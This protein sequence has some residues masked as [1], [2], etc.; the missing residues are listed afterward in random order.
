MIQTDIAIVGG[1]LIGQALALGLARQGLRSV[2]IDRTPAE[3]MRRDDFDGRAYAV[4]L[5][6]RRFLRHLGVWAAIEPD[7]GP[8]NDIL[9]SDSRP[10]ERASPL[11]LRFDH[12]E[13]GPEGF[14]HMVEDRHLRRALL[15]AVAA[16][17]L[18]A[19]LDGVDVLELGKPSGAGVE[20]R[21]ADGRSIEAAV[22]VGADG[23]AGRVARAVGADKIT[24]AYDQV[25]LVCAVAHEK[26]HHGVAHEL[27]LPAGPFAILPLQGGR[28]ASIVWT[29]RKAAAEAFQRMDD[30]AYLSEVARRFGPFLGRLSLIG[31]RW[32]YPLSLSLADRFVAERLALVGDA[33]RGI[34]PIAGQGMNYGLRDAAALAEVLGDAARLGEDIGSEPVLQRYQRMRLA[35]SVAIAMATDGLNRLFSNDV[36]PVRWARRL[37]LAAFGAIGP[38]RR[39]AIRFAAGDRS[40]LPRSMRS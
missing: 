21:L 23:R 39:A 25:G 24:F 7:A 29:E 11:F 32:V 13:L 8:I 9:V 19:R 30:A 17:P 6:S 26:D 15:D 12:R 36:G 28:R 31:R 4:A 35:D 1:G 38:L 20:V 40:D 10:G 14:G 37:G 16:A 3:Q 22:V 2:I 27:F 18:V 34:H 5:A 33:A